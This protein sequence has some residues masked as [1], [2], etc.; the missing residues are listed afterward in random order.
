MSVWVKNLTDQKR[1]ADVSFSAF[2][3]V[4]SKQWVPPRTVGATIHCDF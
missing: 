2:G 1:F 4:I 3:Q